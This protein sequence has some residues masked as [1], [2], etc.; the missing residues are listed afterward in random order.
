MMLKKITLIIAAGL[1]S[2]ATLPSHANQTIVI[3]DFE[4]PGS[5]Q[6]DGWN[7]IGTYPL[8]GGDNVGLVWSSTG[9]GSAAIIVV[10]FAD[11]HGFQ[12]TMQLNDS[13]VA[14]LAD[15]TEPGTGLLMADVYWQ[16]SDW[17][18]IAKV[19]WDQASF[20]SNKTGWLQTDDSMMT[21]AVNPLSPGEWDTLSWF[22]SNQRTITWDFSTLLAG[23]T[24]DDI[25]NDPGSLGYPQL[26]LSVNS[27]TVQEDYGKFFIDNIRMVVSDPVTIPAP[28]ALA[29]TAIGTLLIAIRRRRA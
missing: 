16:T 5:A 9:N 3:G 21:D 10:D 14:R 4:G 23:Y 27:I 13:I 1:L 29:L 25:L 6:L 11:N 2:F 22:S 7:N 18:N 15:S 8:Y 24:S 17:G 26:N 20:N 19:R 12:W 28:G